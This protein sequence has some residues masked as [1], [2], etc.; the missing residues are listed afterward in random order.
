[1]REERSADYVRGYVAAWPVRG[2]DYDAVWH[3]RRDG[4]RIGAQQMRTTAIMAGWLQMR[5]WST[6]REQWSTQVC[7][8][9]VEATLRTVRDWVGGPGDDHGLRPKDRPVPTGPAEIE[10]WVSEVDTGVAAGV[11]AHLSAS[12]VHRGG[13]VGLWW[14][15]RHGQ[16][17]RGRYSSLTPLAARELAAELLA[18]ADAAELADLDQR[19]GPDQPG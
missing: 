2:V 15:N 16:M 13:V 4:K 8:A 10:R 11:E 12:P 7:D 5:A 18:A 6:S 1:M 17:L 9:I 14:R 19:R 3:L